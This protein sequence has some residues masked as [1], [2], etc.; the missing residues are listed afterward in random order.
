MKN[1]GICYKAEQK[2]R[3]QESKVNFLRDILIKTLVYR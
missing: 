3:E 2:S 1:W